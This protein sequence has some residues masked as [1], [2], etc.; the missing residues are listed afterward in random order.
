[1]VIQTE[2]LIDERGKRKSVV[3]SLRDYFKLMEYLENLEDSLDLKKAKESAK[4]FVD[5][6]RFKAQLKKQGRIR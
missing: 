1:M 3:L 4:G 6:S 5:F 2:Y